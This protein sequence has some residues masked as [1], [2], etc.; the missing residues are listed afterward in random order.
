MVRAYECVCVRMSMCV[1]ALIL[2]NTG[3]SCRYIKLCL[4]ARPEFE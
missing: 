4:P 3:F 1:G 2:F